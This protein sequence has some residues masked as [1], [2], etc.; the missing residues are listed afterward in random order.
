MKQALKL[1]EKLGLADRAH[2]SVEQLSG[3]QQQRVAIARALITDPKIIIADEPLTF[4]DIESAKVIMDF[5]E[6]LQKEGRTILISTHLT[7]LAKVAN[8]VY[9]MKDG[10][11]IENS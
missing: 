10:T 8:K 4:V 2:F 11:L 5:F 6:D 9:S 1:L 7:E 3:G